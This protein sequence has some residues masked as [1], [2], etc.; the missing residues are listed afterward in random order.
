MKTLKLWLEWI[1]YFLLTQDERLRYQRGLMKGMHCISRKDVSK[2]LAGSVTEF[3]YDPNKKPF[4][5]YLT[6]KEFFNRKNETKI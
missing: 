6:R 2:I 4:R 5:Q 1:F 3:T